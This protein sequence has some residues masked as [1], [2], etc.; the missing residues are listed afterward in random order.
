MPKTPSFEHAANFIHSRDLIRP[1]LHRIDCEGDIESVVPDCPVVGI[2]TA[3]VNPT[4]KD[5]RSFSSA[6]LCRHFA[7]RVYTGNRRRRPRGKRNTDP[8]PKPI[9]ST[10]ALVRYAAT[11]YDARVARSCGP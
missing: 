5:G 6:R 11:R 3:R 8:D 1:A 2:G 4:S 7:R 9:S 10:H